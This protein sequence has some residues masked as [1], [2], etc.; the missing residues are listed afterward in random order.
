MSKIIAAVLISL[1][2]I[3]CAGGNEEKPAEKPVDQPIKPAVTK[4]EAK[5]N[6]VYSMPGSN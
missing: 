4:K 5:K 2:L 3:G 6:S 1:F